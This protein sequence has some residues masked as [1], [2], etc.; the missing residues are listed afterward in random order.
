[1]KTIFITGAS[2]GIGREA[3]KLFQKK[4]WNVVATMRNPAIEKEL[5]ELHN[6]EVIACDVT[7]L[8]SINKAI[9]KGIKRFGKIDVLLNNA[10]YYTIGPLEAAKDEEIRSQLDTNLLGVIE[11]TKAILPHF[12]KNNSGT[13]INLSSIAGIASI[14]LQSLYHA[15]KFAI[16]GFS[17]SLQYELEKFNIKVRIIEPGTI[18]TNFCGRSMTVTDYGK[19]EEYEE[20]SKKVVNNLINNGNSG[21]DPSGV[22]EII[23]KAATDKSNKMRYRAGK[24]KNMITLRKILPLPIYR[25]VIKASLEK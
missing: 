19:F 9:E 23:Y 1:M 13:I 17:E 24:M 15:T 16:E 22:A 6:V 11:T 18:K 10:G 5:I 2:S 25:C 3:A 21:S 12:R 8:E 20:Y 4:G 7:K 14:P